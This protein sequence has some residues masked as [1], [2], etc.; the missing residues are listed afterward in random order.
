M[1]NPSLYK[2]ILRPIVIR[3]LEENGRMYGFE[4]T[5]KVKA[6]TNGKVKITEG[7]L[8]PLLHSLEAEGILEAEQEFVD[9]RMR[10]YYKLTSKGKK[11]SKHS[12]GEITEFVLHLQNIFNLKLA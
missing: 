7:A 1:N 8:Y 12:F 9:N 3:L 6:I 10:K 2:G 11:V 4:I 5:Q